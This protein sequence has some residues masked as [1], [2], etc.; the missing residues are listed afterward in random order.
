MRLKLKQKRFERFVIAFGL[1]MTILIGL[2]LPGH[3]QGSRM[4]KATCPVM[5]GEKVSEKF[6][7]DYKGK[8]V[9][10]CCKPCIRAFKRNPEK[11]LERMKEK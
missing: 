8:R 3:A 10:L 4:V 2:P 11:Y 1:I 7:V 5:L 6:F 9:F